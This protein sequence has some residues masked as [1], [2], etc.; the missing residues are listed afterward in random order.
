MCIKALRRCILAL[1]ISQPILVFATPHDMEVATE[2]RLTDTERLRQ[3][4]AAPLALTDSPPMLVE[5]DPT[6]KPYNPS[7]SQPTRN[8]HR[9]PQS[10]V[11]KSNTRAPASTLA[12]HFKRYAKHYFGESAGQKK[13]RG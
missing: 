13:G 10:V 9:Q 4:N 6:A 5:G 7:L 11:R 8:Q 2:I 12:R 3:I 1:V